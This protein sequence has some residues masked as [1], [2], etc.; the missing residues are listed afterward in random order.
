MVFVVCCLVREGSS[1]P[2]KDWFGCTLEVD[3]ILS[4][5]YREFCNGNRKNGFIEKKKKKKA[6]ARPGKFEMGGR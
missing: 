2:I 1:T 6:S 5:L 3:I 4:D